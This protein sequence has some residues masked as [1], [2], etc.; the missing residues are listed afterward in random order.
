MITFSRRAISA[1]AAGI[2]DSQTGESGLDIPTVI[3][4]EGILWLYFDGSS[5][6]PPW[7]CC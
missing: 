4:V 3:N 7:C 5:S 1:T 6:P 2:S